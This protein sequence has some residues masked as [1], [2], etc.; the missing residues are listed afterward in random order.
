MRDRRGERG[1]LRDTPRVRVVTHTPAR[2]FTVKMCRAIARAKSRRLIATG[3]LG[4]IVSYTRIA[5]HNSFRAGHHP[6]AVARFRSDLSIFG[7]SRSKKRPGL[8]PPTRDAFHASDATS[9]FGRASREPYP[10]VVG[11][12]DI[13]GMTDNTMALIPRRAMKRVKRCP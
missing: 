7:R 3:S 9:S 13:S 8:A 5:D 11:P 12:S 2:S 4:T 6:I 10:L 1:G